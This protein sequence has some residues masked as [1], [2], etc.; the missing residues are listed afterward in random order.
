M[1][2]PL[3]GADDFE[4]DEMDVADQV[5][6][7]D[8]GRPWAARAIRHPSHAATRRHCKDNPLPAQQN[9]RAS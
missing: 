6:Y 9:R 7:E 2:H 3:D 8:T 5:A 1:S 4:P